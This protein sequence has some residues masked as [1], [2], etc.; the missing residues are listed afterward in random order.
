[1]IP[2]DEEF[3]VYVSEGVLMEVWR[4][5]RLSVAQQFGLR[6]DGPTHSTMQS[7]V[8]HSPVSKGLATRVRRARVRRLLSRRAQRSAL[9]LLLALALGCALGWILA[10]QW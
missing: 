2:R 7:L 5:P 3:D 1:M 8:F 4:G 10:R 6:W 9:W